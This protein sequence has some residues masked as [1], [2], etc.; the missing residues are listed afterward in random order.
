MMSETRAKLR[1]LHERLQITCIIS[2][3]SALFHIVYPKYPN[4]SHALQNFLVACT[5]LART[6]SCVPLQKM[7]VAK[8]VGMQ[9]LTLVD[10][11]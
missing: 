2:R 3:T 10:D 9:A 6:E 11:I 5:R 8:L 7:F 1:R 4:N